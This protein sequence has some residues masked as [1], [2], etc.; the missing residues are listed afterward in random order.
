YA[1]I[2]NSG[3]AD[4]EVTTEAQDN[5]TEITTT[6]SETEQW[7]AASSTWTTDGTWNIWAGN[8]ATAQYKGNGTLND[9]YVNTITTTGDW[10]VQTNTIVTGLTAGTLY[11]YTITI[12]SDKEGAYVGAKEDYSNS[13]LVYK[14]LSVGENTITGTF[15]AAQANAKL[16]LEMGNA[17]NTGAT[18]HIT[19]VTVSEYADDDS[20]GI[21]ADGKWLGWFE[22]EGWASYTVSEV[23]SGYTLSNK[24]IGQNW[25]SIQT[26]IDNVKFKSGVDYTCAF[27]LTSDKPKQFKIDNRSNDGTVFTETAAGTWS[28]NGDGTYSYKYVGTYKNE[29]ASAQFINLRIS[30]GYFTGEENYGAASTLN[31]TVSNFVIVPTSEYGKEPATTAAPTTAAPTTVAP[32]TAA[33][34]TAAPTTAAPTTTAPTETTT[35][36]PEDTTTAPT[37]TTTGKSEETTT[38][39]P[40]IETTPTVVESTTQKQTTNQTTTA[41][42]TTTKTTAVT[43][44]A[45]KVKKG[46]KSKSSKKI[47]LTLKKIK[48]AKGYQIQISTNKKFKKKLVKKTVKKVN[49]TIKSKKIVNKKKLYARVRTYKV[50]NGKK[51]YSKWSKAKKVKIK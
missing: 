43:V 24:N 36:K 34:T 35:V 20:E 27:T 39:V 45:S 23:T 31:C 38:V 46:T 11:R 47:K 19:G 30:L 6:A 2:V 8:G 37:E 48:G 17:A 14:T 1:G 18:F 50:I 25:Y 13:S 44:K 10:S 32:T 5:T 12:G 40:P 33:P 41:T 42:Q 16:F 26:G 21:P 15:T 29:T 49:V 51:Y 4:S 28:Q 9:Y 3:E 7:N 22:A